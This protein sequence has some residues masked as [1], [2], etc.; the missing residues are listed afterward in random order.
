MKKTTIT[1]TENE[2]TNIINALTYKAD[3]IADTGKAQELVN[4]ELWLRAVRQE[5]R[6]D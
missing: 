5:L 1:L 6:D 4:L 3:R 2:L